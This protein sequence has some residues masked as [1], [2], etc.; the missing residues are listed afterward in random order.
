MENKNDIF[1]SDNPLDYGS[2]GEKWSEEFVLYIKQIATH[3]VYAGMPDAIKEDGKIQWEAPSN[4][5]SGKYQFTHQK[6]RQWWQDKAKS[7]GIDYNTD[8]QY[9]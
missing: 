7:V 6:R 8:R 9:S 1:I 3:S 2:K 4:R 5:S